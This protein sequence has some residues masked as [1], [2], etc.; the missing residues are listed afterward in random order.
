MLIEDGHEIGAH[1]YTEGM[2]VTALDR[3]GQRDSIERSIELIQSLTGELPKCWL[4][5][6]ASADR[7]TLELLAEAGIGANADLQDDELPYFLHVGDKTLVE[8]PYRMIGNLNDVP[9]TTVLGAL[10]SVGAAQR[11]LREAFDAYYEEAATFPVILNFGTHPHVI[12]RPD[13]IKILREFMEYVAGHSDVWICTSGEIADWW[14]QQ[15]GHLVVE[16]G[17]DIH[18]TDAPAS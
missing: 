6:G 4:G 13:T 10:Y 2:P 8:I 15:F 7:N 12:G 3:E 17:G 16:G 11:H 18:V 5:Q 14:R 9:L 1:G